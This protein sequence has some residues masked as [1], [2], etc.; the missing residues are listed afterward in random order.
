MC[1]KNEP[2]TSCQTGCPQPNKPHIPQNHLIP[3]APSI[4]QSAQQNWPHPLFNLPHSPIIPN[5]N[6]RLPEPRPTWKGVLAAVPEFIHQYRVRCSSFQERFLS[7]S[8]S[9]GILRFFSSFRI[10]LRCC[11]FRRYLILILFKSSSLMKCCCSSE[12]WC[13]QSVFSA[14]LG[15][16]KTE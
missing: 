3:N 13:C 14:T 7:I 5:P 12:T 11:K 2:T 8:A 16:L 10:A 6:P 4:S 1:A 15:Q 9:V